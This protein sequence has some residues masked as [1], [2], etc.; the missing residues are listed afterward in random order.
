[1]NS[2]LDLKKNTSPKFLKKVGEEMLPCR[3]ILVEYF[4]LE[5][6]QSW[7]RKTFVEKEE[8][9]ERCLQIQVF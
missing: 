9:Q 1:M 2:Y 6:G 8:H 3:N 4:S 5:N 7:Q